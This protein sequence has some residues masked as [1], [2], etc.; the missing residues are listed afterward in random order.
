MRARTR[1][2]W[3]RSSSDAPRRRLDASEVEEAE[4]FL[5]WLAD[6]H[7]TF[8]GYR[9]YDL[10]GRGWTRR[11]CSVDPDS[12]LGILRDAGAPSSDRADAAR[13]CELA[14]SPQL[15]GAD[16]GQLALD[17]APARLPGLR[18]RQALRPRRPGDRRAPLPRALH[19]RRLQSERAR[20]PAAARQGRLRAGAR[21]LPARQPRRQGADRDPRVLSRATRCSRSTDDEL[22]EMAMGILGLGERQRVRLFVQPR[23]ARPLRRLP[24]LHAARPLQH[25]EPR[26]GRRRSSSRRSAAATSTGACSSPS[27]CSSGS[28]T[29]CTA[30]R[31]PRRRT[32][33]PR[34][35]RGSSQATRA[36]TDD[37]RDALVDEL[38]EERGSQLHSRYERRLPAGLPRR[39]G[40]ARGGRRHR[41][42]RGAGRR[43][44]TDHQPL[45]AARGADGVDALQALQLAE[46]SLSDVLPTFEHMGAGSSTSGPTRSRRDGATPVWIYDFGLRCAGRRR[47]SAVRERFEEAFLGVWRGELENDGL[48]G[49]VLAAGLTRRARSRSSARSP[50]TCARRGSPFSDAYMERTLIAHPDIATLL[51]AL[52]DAR[53]D[54]DA[55]DAGPA[56]ARSRP[57]S[58]A[59]IDAVAEPRRG[60]DPAQLPVRRAGDPAHQLLLPR[61]GGTAPAA[62]TCRSSSTRRSSRSCRCRARSSRS[63]STRRGSRASICAAAGRARR[64]ALVG[65]ARGLPHR[66]PRPDEGADGQE[67]ADRA[68]RLQG[69]L[70]GQAPAGRRR[71]RGAPG[72]RPS[73]ATRRSCRGL[74]DLTDNI[75]GGEVVPPDARRPLRRATIPTWWSPPTRAPRPS[76][77]SPT[78]SRPSYGFW[79]G[80]AFASGG[81]HGY[82]HKA[83]GITARGAWESVKRHFRELGTDIQTT[84]FTVVGIGDMSGDVFGN[85]MLLSPPHQAARPRSTTCTCSSTPTPIRRRSFAERE[86]LFELAALGLERLRPGADLRGRR[87]LRAHRQV[88]PDLR[89]R[90]ARR[91]GSRPSELSPDRADP[92]RSCGRRS[93]CSGTAASAPT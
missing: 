37:L 1:A 39:L 45:P 66:D 50:T 56:R 82:D 67:R 24:G 65:P 88:D 63:S 86:R 14:R 12:G 29:S 8:L 68:G 74:L 38:G 62:A 69:R 2:R 79:L 71:A 49:L 72:R 83:M 9:E 20:D 53:F 47:W 17:R 48:N 41:A 51:V 34:S 18:R 60:P 64:A 78:R 15:A 91:S 26:A 42:D 57:R 89:R 21:R 4:A 3:P 25:R 28:T 31:R 6:D 32:T 10:R 46:V 11:R 7:F 35:R 19:D 5:R 16:Q 23:P 92:R 59:A 77:T 54:P 55:H 44:P 43:R 76:P 84:D 90:S 61:C 27:R 36:W 40:A 93:T 87:R 85:G 80:D 73:P 33:W 52:F 75:V 30:R 13:R 22:F 81:S 70:R 58:S